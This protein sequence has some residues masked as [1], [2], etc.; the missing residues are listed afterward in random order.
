MLVKNSEPLSVE[1]SREVFPKGVEE[2]VVRL[3]GLLSRSVEEVDL[4]WGQALLEIVIF[5]NL[6]DPFDMIRFQQ[7]F[8]H[9]V[10]VLERLVIKTFCE[11]LTELI[12]EFGK[13][14]TLLVLQELKL[15]VKL[16]FKGCHV[17][18][19]ENLALLEI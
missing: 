12:F 1:V 15:G 2:L 14:G 7:I 19:F 9:K 16:L 18:L 13:I 3:D 6:F 10:F 8:L 4:I 17:F 11:V 5:Q